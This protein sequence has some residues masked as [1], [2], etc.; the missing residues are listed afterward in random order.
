MSMAGIA[1]S[2]IFGSIGLGA[3][4]YGKKQSNFKVLGIGIAYLEKH[5]RGPQEDLGR[6]G[7]LEDDAPIEGKEIGP[8]RLDDV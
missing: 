2:I 3:F 7:V 1:A 6:C 5:K 4:I 8:P